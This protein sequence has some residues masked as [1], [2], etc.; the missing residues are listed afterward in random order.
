MEETAEFVECLQ[1]LK[2]KTEKC[3]S[4]LNQFEENIKEAEGEFS[5]LGLPEMAKTEIKQV[6]E[7]MVHL[8]KANMVAVIANTR[9]FRDLV[10]RILGETGDILDEMEKE[11]DNIKKKIG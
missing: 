5:G 2:K 6:E 10:D 3:I 8:V 9:H 11:L 7:I 4:L 1:K